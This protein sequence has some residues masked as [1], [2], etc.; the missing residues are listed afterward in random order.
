MRKLRK[1]TI[2]TLIGVFCSLLTFA[3]KDKI[4]VEGEWNEKDLRSIFSGPPAVSLEGNVVYIEFKR[5]LSNLTV[6][7]AG[8]NNNFYYQ[9][10]ISSGPNSSYEVP[11]TLPEGEYTIYL[12]HGYGTLTGVFEVE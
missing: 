5:A 4:P 12:T 3:A 8:T 7:I 1:V 2:F 9:E 6:T 11:Y 10:T